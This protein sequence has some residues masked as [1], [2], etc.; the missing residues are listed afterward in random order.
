MGNKTKRLI[1]I[2]INQQ[3]RY[4][5]HCI[6]ELSMDKIWVPFSKTSKSSPWFSPLTLAVNYSKNGYLLKEYIRGRGSSPSRQVR[7]EDN[8]FKPGFSYMGRATR[9][10][11]FIVPYGVIPTARRAQIFPYKDSEYTVLGI[12]AS[13]IG[14]AVARLSGEIFSAPNY[15]ASMVQG[16]PA[17]DF[18]EA[19]LQEIQSHVDA[20][21]NKRR[22]VV[23]LY[24]PYQEF[25]L[26]AWLQVDQA[27][28][29]EWDLYSLFGKEL[30]NKIAAAYGLNAE[31]LTELERDIREAV[32]IRAPSDDTESAE[33][34]D[35]DTD[36]EQELNI[37]LID[38]TPEA[39]AAG[40]LMYAV[41][42]VFGRWDV[43]MAI[44][45]S[46]IPKLP[47]PFDPLPVCPPA[48]LVG[49]D[50]LPAKAGAIAG[51]EW[52]RARPDAGILPAE[53]AVAS[54]T[55]PNA[56]YP[57]PVAWDGILVDDPGHTWD[58]TTH[59][60]KVLQ[61]L[62][63]ENGENIETEAVH[64]AGAAS[65]QEY[66]QRQ[67][68]FFADHF[69]EYSKNRR[70][71]P[72]YWPLSTPSGLYTV[73]LYYHRLTDQTLYTCVNDFVDPKLKQVSE[74]ITGLRG[75]SRSSSDE[76]QLERLIDLEL[77]LRDFR[78]E[79]LRIAA[80]WKPNSN[81]GVELTAAPLWKLVQHRQW[82][83]RL[84]ATWEKLEAG[85]YDWAHLALGIWP[86]RVVRASH[87]DH[88]Y[89]IAHDLEE[90]LW[91]EVEVERRGRGRGTASTEWR[92]RNLNEADLRDII[93]MAKAR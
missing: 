90:Q 80:F 70:Y 19:T 6:N 18:P 37:Q 77:E 34:A 31:Q 53:N 29:T 54:P 68:G 60:R 2:A 71:A 55:I 72:I 46:L 5:H 25:S 22:A 9:L 63:G 39:K 15:Q 66:L 14:S 56:S 75:K 85:D 42:V 81:D 24:E 27:G 21:V 67:S 91:H 79:L 48:T 38:E 57:L 84:K 16:L 17:C 73:W 28:A 3:N 23:R 65:L 62:F 47:A 50:G 93:D 86:E 88:S 26:P 36:D 58:V 20:E 30:E 76:K 35:D 83:A 69:G 74:D 45:H 8:Y 10:I 12:C 89:A 52:L 64:L 87:K 61:L 59:S 4:S 92:P 49:P 51:E 78:A 1:S 7:S 32:A 44:D 11:P 40:L 82:K 33:S 43:R 13:N 41:G